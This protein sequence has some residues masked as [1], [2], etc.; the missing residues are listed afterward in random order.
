LRPSVLLIVFG[1]FLNSS[2]GYSNVENLPERL[3]CYVGSSYRLDIRVKDGNASVYMGPF[4]EEANYEYDKVVLSFDETMSDPVLSFFGTDSASDAF[5]ETHLTR[6][7]FEQY[8]SYQGPLIWKSAN[9]SIRKEIIR[10][11]R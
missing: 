2:I 8:V 9:G 10:N 11:C 5:F 7:Q 1:S 3:G 6:H 4:G